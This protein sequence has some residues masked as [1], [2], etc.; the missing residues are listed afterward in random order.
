MNDDV[1]VGKMKEIRVALMYV[2]GIREGA[3]SKKTP[4]VES[5]AFPVRVT[6]VPT[7]TWLLGVTEEMNG[8]IVFKPPY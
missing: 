2:K 7:V 5:N 6:D 4:V 1:P 8:T 3:K